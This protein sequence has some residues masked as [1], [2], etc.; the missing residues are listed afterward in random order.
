MIMV[1]GVEVG[2]RNK[3]N[4][5]HHHTAQRR[6]RERERER[7]RV[8]ALRQLRFVSNFASKEEDK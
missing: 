5:P 4:M 7:E 6:E 2:C 8:N 1:S 3:S